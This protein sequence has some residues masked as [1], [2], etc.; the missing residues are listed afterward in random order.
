VNE[1]D[2]GRALLR[3]G[4]AELG[5]VPDT[6]QMTWQIIERDRQRVRLLTALTVG[7][8]LLATVFVLAGLVGY[9]F[10][11]PEQAKLLREIE[12]GELTP[13]QRDQAQRA[14]LVG[15]QKG[16]LLIAFSVAVLALTTLG[17]VLLLFASRRATLR[18][19]NA[20]LMEIAEQLRRLRPAPPPAAGGP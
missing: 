10:L 5:G 16:T 17:T 6:R 4:A 13:A 9:G 3:L 11:M 14:L 7:V 12:A 2:L 19:V 15:F 18:Q 20:S 1:K 8:W